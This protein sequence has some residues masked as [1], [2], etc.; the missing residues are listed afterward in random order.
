MKTV[1]KINT[2][3]SWKSKTTAHVLAKGYLTN[4]YPFYFSR[5]KSKKQWSILYHLL[6]VNDGICNR[7]VKPIVANVPIA[8]AV[9][10]KIARAIG[11][12]PATTWCVPYPSCFFCLVQKIREC[13]CHCIILLHSDKGSLW[14]LS[15]SLR[16]R[17]LWI[18]FALRLADVLLKV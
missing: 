11:F 18:L 1:N 6:S 3:S 10:R 2:S 12:A 14:S 16:I 9:D 8:R 17:L 5:S 13:H 15:N 7:A 4:R